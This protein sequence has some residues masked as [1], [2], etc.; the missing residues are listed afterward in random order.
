MRILII[1]PINIRAHGVNGGKL[2]RDRNINILMKIFGENVDIYNVPYYNSKISSFLYS[3]GGYI[4]GLKPNIIEHIKRLVISLKFDFIFINTS[5]FGTINKLLKKRNIITF[6]ENIEINFHKQSLKKANFFKN[7][8]Y[9]W[10]KSALFNSEKN[11]VRYS[12]K[13]IVLNKR[14]SQE[15]KRIYHREANF[16]IPISIGDRYNSIDAEKWNKKIDD[17]V[18]LFI[19]SDFFGNTEGLFWFLDNCFEKINAKLFVVGSGMDKYTGKYPCEKVDFIGYV[20]DVSEYYYQADAVVLPIIS[21][22]GMKTKTCEALM[23][24]KTIF[25]TSE[26]FEGY[27]ALDLINNNW[28]CNTKD[29]FII[30]INEYL[31]NKVSKINNYSRDIFLKYYSDLALENIW[32]DVFKK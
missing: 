26:A 16:I 15:L 22:S 6:F 14:D 19:G 28:L 21:G 1:N 8:L 13:I 23:Y 32:A 24:G 4:G 18:L 12:H 10:T 27:D 5:K 9:Y 25:G 29:D 7:M 3:L 17:N 2:F 30:K 20:D 11:A 31:K